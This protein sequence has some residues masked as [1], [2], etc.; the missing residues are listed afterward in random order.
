MADASFVESTG[1]E[2]AQVVGEFANRVAE[3]LLPARMAAAEMASSYSCSGVDVALSSIEINSVE[4]AQPIPEFETRSAGPWESDSLVEEM[5][6]LPN[7]MPSED[8]RPS[9]SPP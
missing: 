5:A 6:S 8:A 2:A 4:S 1:S 7:S 3:L 9:T